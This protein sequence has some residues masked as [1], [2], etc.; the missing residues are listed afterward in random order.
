[1]NDADLEMAQM[2][3]QANAA[4]RAVRQGRCDHG[5]LQ[6]RICNGCALHM[7]DHRSWLYAMRCAEERECWECG[8]DATERHGTCS[9]CADSSVVSAPMYFEVWS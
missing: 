1:M 7:A 8:D 2:T 3:A 4:A 5:S 6:G 9:A